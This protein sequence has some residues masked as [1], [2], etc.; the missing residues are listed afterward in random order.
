LVTLTSQAALKKSKDKFSIWAYMM[1]QTAFA[2]L[3]TGYSLI[4]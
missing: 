3:T 1:K 4:E 2:S